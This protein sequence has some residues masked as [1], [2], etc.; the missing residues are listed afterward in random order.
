MM[1]K[2]HTM[3]MHKSWPRAGSFRA[4]LRKIAESLRQVAEIP[5]GYQDETGF[6]FGVEPVRKEGR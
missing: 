3:T 2:Q 5:T 4:N 6:H 1:Q